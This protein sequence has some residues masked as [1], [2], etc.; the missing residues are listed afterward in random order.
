MALV[1][2][3]KKMQLCV[4]GIWSAEV[5]YSGNL[6]DFTKDIELFKAGQYPA[7]ISMIQESA[8]GGSA[9][10]VEKINQLVAADAVLLYEGEPLTYEGEPVTYN[11]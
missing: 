2:T 9:A 10:L 5:E 1:K 4:N 11:L 8:G 7:R 6:D 3:V